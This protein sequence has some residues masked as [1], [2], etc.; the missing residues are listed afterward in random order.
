M[1]QPRPQAVV[2]SRTP[3]SVLCAISAASV[4]LA[5]SAPAPA[6]LVQP[7][8]APRAQPMVVVDDALNMTLSDEP[9]RLDER[10]L[11]F[12]VEGEERTLPR[13]RVLALGPAEW[14]LGRGANARAVVAGV[15]DS[16]QARLTFTDGSRLHGVVPMT[17]FE[18]ETFVL[19][20]A[21]LGVLSFALCG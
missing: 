5:A 6:Q 18:P 10:T 12:R 7:S 9:I 2:R 17:A 4:V 11:T 13:E 1:N 8:N 14:A 15:G 21:R 20:H 16:G 19:R 3:A